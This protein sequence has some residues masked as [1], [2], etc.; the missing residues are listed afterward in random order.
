MQ[1]RLGV[2]I[3]CRAAH[4]A[5]CADQTG[6][7]VWSGHQ[8]RTRA[9]EL[10]ALWA[11]LPGDATEVLVVME[12][13]RNAWVP[14]AAW[15]RRRGAT[16]VLVPAEQSADLRAYYAKHTKT[17][18]LD[19][20]LLARLPL[21]HPDGLHPETTN[22]PGD[23]LKRAVKIRSGLVHRRTACMQRLDAL[24]E[25]LGPDW[26]AA[27]GSDMTQTAFKFLAG[28]ANPHQVKR[29]GRA[30]LARWFQ[31]QTRKAWGERRADAVVAAAEA[32]LALW[33]PT[34]LDYEA[35][36]ADIATEASLALE[37]S[38]QIARLDERIFDLYCDADP[39]H[40]LLSVPGVGKI[41]ASSD[42]RPARRPP[43]VHQPGRGP[44]VLRAHPAPA[45]LRPHRRHRRPDQTR[46][47]LPP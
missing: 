3:A 30:R 44:V 10:E 23:P 20:E 19:A 12:P 5:A 9:E 39:D 41:L 29:L 21:L 11:R 22:G 42:P 36:A 25:I 38:R 43:P 31:R 35:L 18:R 15:F 32:T 2:D 40:I 14:L 27:L 33:G 8:F 28:W 17:D 45:L 37:L 1:V 47:R 13:T 4:R 24:L 26:V 46:R 6:M 7:I 16:V 34:G